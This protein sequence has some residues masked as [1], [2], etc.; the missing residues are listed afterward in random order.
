MPQDRDTDA[1]KGDLDKKRSC[2]HCGGI[3]DEDGFAREMVDD[4]EEAGGA[5]ESAPGDEGANLGPNGFA[6]A[7]RRRGVR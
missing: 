3:V 4:S 5:A 6:D 2:A 1:P 7:I